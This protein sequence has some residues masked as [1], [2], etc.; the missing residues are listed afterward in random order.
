MASYPQRRKREEIELDRLRFEL[1]AR[2]VLLALAVILC[3]GATAAAIICALHGSA[4]PTA[5]LGLSGGALGALVVKGASSSA[6]EA[7]DGALVK[8]LASLVDE[9]SAGQDER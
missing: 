7:S 8:T 4:L 5:G 3:L 9:E 1:F 6:D 2:R